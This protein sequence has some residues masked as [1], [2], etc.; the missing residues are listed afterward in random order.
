MSK[1]P[2]CPRCNVIR[3]TFK[4]TPPPMTI[5]NMITLFMD[6]PCIQCHTL[7]MI[8]LG[9]LCIL[10]DGSKSELGVVLTKAVHPKFDPELN[11]FSWQISRKS[12]T[13]LCTKC[14]SKPAKDA[15][16]RAFIRLKTILFNFP[17][18]FQE[19]FNF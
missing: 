1:T 16:R 17:K 5:A 19:I 3:I 7:C 8:W 9:D 6:S 14:A 13:T 12:K 10:I 11:V 2:F 4:N 15:C 18:R